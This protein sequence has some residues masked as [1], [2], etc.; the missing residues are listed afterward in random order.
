MFGDPL[1]HF[2]GTLRCA[3]SE[4]FVENLIF[5]NFCVKHRKLGM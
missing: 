3:P 5:D 2:C 4:F 1:L